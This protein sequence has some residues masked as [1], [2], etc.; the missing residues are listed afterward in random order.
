MARNRLFQTRKHQLDNNRLLSEK[1]I[2]LRKS[3]ENFGEKNILL[4][5]AEKI[6]DLGAW[7]FEIKED[8]WTMSDQ[9]LKIH[10]SNN[11]NPSTQQLLPLSYSKTTDRC[12]TQIF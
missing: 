10:G 3:E 6:A 7:M 11:R 12:L 9:W 4:G 8:R 1:N 5:E 2:L